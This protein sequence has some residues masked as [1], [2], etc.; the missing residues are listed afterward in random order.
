MQEKGQPAGNGPFIA[1]LDEEQE[2]EEHR[3][4][5]AEILQCLA[6]SGLRA[7]G[8]RGE[9]FAGVNPGEESGYQGHED[10]DAGDAVDVDCAEDEQG[11]RQA[12]EAVEDSGFVDGPGRVGLVAGRDGV[13]QRQ[14][15]QAGAR[16]QHQESGDAPPVGEGR[17]YQREVEESQAGEAA[18]ED[19][20][21]GDAAAEHDGP[22][23]T[24]GD[25]NSDGEGEEVVADGDEIGQVVKVDPGGQDGAEEGQKKTGDEEARQGAAAAGRTGVLVAFCGAACEVHCFDCIIVTLPR[26]G[27]SHIH[28]V[29]GL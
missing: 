16:S 12:A 20:L 5:A 11:G 28:G 19:Q 22:G 18:S 23:E 13:E 17:R 21:E 6:E 8:R 2:G 27:I 29:S 7:L 4:R 26:W 14:I 9:G 15:E 10:Q 24:R 1:E 25:H 3:A